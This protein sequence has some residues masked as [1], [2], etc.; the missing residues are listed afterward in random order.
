MHHTQT[1]SHARDRRYDTTQTAAWAHRQA[2]CRAA[3][4]SCPVAE[5]WTRTDTTANAHKYTSMHASGSA[6]AYL[7]VAQPPMH[8][9]TRRAPPSGAPACA[10]FHP[11][12]C[13]RFAYARSMVAMATV[14]K[15]QDVNCAACAHKS[16]YMRSAHALKVHRRICKRADSLTHAKYR[17]MLAACS[18]KAQVHATLPSPRMS[19][20]MNAL[21]VCVR[22]RK[23]AEPSAHAPAFI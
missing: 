9:G 5:W 12:H 22:I 16:Q 15:A 4:Y 11:V 8:H 19:R 18:R 3:K 17:R 20:A 2:E 7:R 10:Q 1:R 13:T 21:A 14:A 23:H 6:S